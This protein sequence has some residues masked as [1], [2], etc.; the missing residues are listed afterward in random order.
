MFPIIDKQE[1][2]INLRKIMNERNL[3]VKDV[4]QYLGLGSVQSVYHWLNGISM[5]TIDNLYALRELFKLPIDA[6]V[7]GN[8]KP[9]VTGFRLEKIDLRNK[10][11][12][13]YYQKL[14]DLQVA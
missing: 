9:L 3:T 12:Y 4:Q 14:I 8:R 5:P 11:L 1:T 6:M 13:M 7:C 2:G 10:R